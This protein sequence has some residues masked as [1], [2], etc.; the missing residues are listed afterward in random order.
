MFENTDD[1]NVVTY[2]DIARWCD[3]LGTL[4][5]ENPDRPELWLTKSIILQRQVQ[6]AVAI[7]KLTKDE[8]PSPQ[9][10]ER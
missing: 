9:E 1:P 6:A 7:V 4:I 10:T 3:E 5:R 2:N 8:T